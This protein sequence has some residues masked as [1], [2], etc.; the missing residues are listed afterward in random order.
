MHVSQSKGEQPGGLIEEGIVALE[1]FVKVAEESGV[2][3]AIEN[4]MQP[5]LLDFVFSRIRS[6]HL[7]FCYDTSHDFLYSPEAVE[8]LDDG[9][10]ASWRSTS[11]IMTGFWTATGCPGWEFWIGRRLSAGYP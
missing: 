4:T 6:D 8:L 11:V 9:G 10:I 2:G 1:G 5:A 7:G 3:I